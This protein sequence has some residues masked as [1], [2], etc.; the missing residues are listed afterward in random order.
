MVQGLYADNFP[1][2]TN[3]AAMYKRFQQTLLNGLRLNDELKSGNVAVYLGNRITIDSNI[4]SINIDQTQYIVEL[5]AR[6]EMSVSQ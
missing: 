6:F 1:H 4:L 5:L 3:D 2:H